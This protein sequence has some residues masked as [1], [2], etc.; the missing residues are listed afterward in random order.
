MYSITVSSPPAQEPVSTT[1]LQSYL[2]VNTSTE[3][4]LLSG[5]LVAARLLFERESNL[6]L[7]TQTMVESLEVPPPYITYLMR[8]PIQSVTS[9]QYYDQNDTLQTATGYNLDLVTGGMGRLWFPNGQPTMSVNVRPVMNITFQAGYGDN[10]SNVP[11]PISQAIM[12]CAAYWF[13]QRTAYSDTTIQNVPMGFEAIV[14]AY[15]VGNL[16]QWGMDWNDRRKHAGYP[17]GAFP[18]MANQD[19]GYWGW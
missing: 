7:I 17:A 16:Y 9:V 10:P 1:T 19:G 12:L 3:N 5:F 2:R 18:W 8:G 6:A 15:K 4:S 14:D 13:E 11:A